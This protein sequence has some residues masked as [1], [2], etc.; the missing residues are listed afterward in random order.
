MGKNFPKSK[1]NIK[2]KLTIPKIEKAIGETMPI[3]LVKEACSNCVNISPKRNM[4]EITPSVTINP[5]LMNLL[6]TFS[7]SLEIW[8]AR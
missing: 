3:A 2:N 4:E 7:S 1:L 8:P 5:S 6:L